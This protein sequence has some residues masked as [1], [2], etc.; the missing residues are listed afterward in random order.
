MANTATRLSA[1]GSLTINGS[2]D[3]VTYNPTSNVVVN[4]LD[5][6]QDYSNAYWAK[7]LTINSTSEL[8]PD[9]SYTATL[10]TFNLTF[11]N[12]NSSSNKFQNSFDKTYT[13]SV[14]AKTTAT[15]IA[16]V[17][18][19]NFCNFNLDTGLAGNPNF[20]TSKIS[21]E[22][23]GFYR[24]S[25]TF[26]STAQTE[27][28]GIW[29]G[30][31]NGSTFT[32]K[33][34]T[35]WGEQVELG[36]TLSP[37]QPRDATN[38]LVSNTASKLL[39]SSSNNS[40]LYIK[41]EFDEVA[42]NQNN[43]GPTKNLV[44]NSEDFT[45]SY[46]WTGGG[47]TLTKNYGPS[48]DGYNNSMMFTGTGL[49][50][51]IQYYPVTNNGYQFGVPGKYYTLSMFVKYVNQRYCI[52]VTETW[53]SPY[54]GVARFDLL[55]GAV[56]SLQANVTNIAMTPYPNGWWRISATYV[57]PS[58][59]YQS[60]QPQWR[61]GNYDGTDYT[62]QQ[63][64]V[65]GFQ[66]EEGNTATIYQATGYPRNL[67]SMTD[68][69]TGQ[70]YKQDC[71]VGYNTTIDPNGGYSAASLTST[72]TGGINT[73]FIQQQLA[74]LPQNTNFT[75]SVYLKPG[76]SPTTQLNF[77]NISPFSELNTLITWPTVPGNY[78]TLTNS[79][80]ATRLATTVTQAANGWWRFSI[81]MNN[82]SNSGLM[83]RIYA[84]TNASTNVNGY[85]VYMWG[86]Q[87]E[88]GLTPTAFTPNIGIPVSILPLANTNM[89]M[90][91]TST[92]NNYIKGSYDEFNKNISVTD[93]LI[94]YLDAGKYDSYQGTGNVW[95]DMS[96]SKNHASLN[97]IVYEYANDAFLMTG[98]ATSNIVCMNLSSYSALTIDAW[99]WFSRSV[100]NATEQDLWT[101]N[102]NPAG[103][104]TGGSFTF[105]S[106]NFRT[107]RNGVS[108]RQYFGAAAPRGQWFRFCY[109]KDGNAYINQT[110]YTSSGT[111]NPYGQLII[112]QSRTDVNMP[113]LG[114]IGHIKIYN[115]A[116]TLAEINQN[117]TDLRSRFGI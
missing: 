86:P 101:Y 114:K 70:W 69:T 93:G 105:Q 31:Y 47:G 109:I 5:Y 79:G 13:F 54:G 74:Y 77:Y 112:G 64:L 104:T 106:G 50:P 2:F 100:G 40:T 9:N 14:Y 89:V 92:G 24:C 51:R 78:P 85:S 95:I 30:G 18:S 49:Y 11:A 38:I 110:E 12:L 1:N 37:Y 25:V 45:Q 82:G 113:F 75:Y 76:T 71:I 67:L 35:L 59:P 108:G 27:T 72:I 90:K 65:W 73:A 48:P 4:L 39:N 96:G 57:I 43:I 60:W 94:M 84:T 15:Y 97:N 53:P 21:K 62:G 34:M 61:L 10:L 20:G 117:F 80:G 102:G 81:S 19:S 87:L 107:D 98:S 17:T 58:V 83:W 46:T 52:F 36:T 99:L 116:L 103:S 7:R 32:D 28:F 66:I 22:A 6:T 56:S 63:M 41:S 16:L 33:T 115:R 44:S 3:E 68:F 91:T 42:Y 88:I 26:T 111:D 23:N 29:L 55:T 8:A